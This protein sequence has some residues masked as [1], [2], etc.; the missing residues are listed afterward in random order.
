MEFKRNPVT[1]DQHTKK[2]GIFKDNMD[3][4]QHSGLLL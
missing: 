3:G 4:A 2:R 1:I